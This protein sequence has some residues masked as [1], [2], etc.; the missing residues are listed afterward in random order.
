MTYIKNK[1]LTEPPLLYLFRREG[2]YGEYFDQ[3]F[4]DDTR[5]RRR[6]Q[7]LSVDMKAIQEICDAFKEVY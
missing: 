4:Y 2:K 7:D 1:P 3:Y 5:H 6:K